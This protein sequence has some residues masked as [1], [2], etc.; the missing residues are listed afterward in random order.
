MKNFL[1]S[2]LILIVGIIVPI[3]LPTLLDFSQDFLANQEIPF[4]SAQIAGIQKYNIPPIS[5]GVVVPEVSA[6]ALL[7]KDL[8][9]DTI[10]LQKNADVPLPIASTTKIMT[11][12]VAEKYFKQNDVL[13]VSKDSLAGGSSAG[14]NLGENLSFR[15]LLYGMLLNSGNDAAY[16][17]A[18]NYP[19]GLPAFMAAMNKEA[20]DLGLKNTHF[21]NPAGFDS[22]NHFSS[23]DDMAIISQ[24]ALKQADLARVFATKETD[25]LSLDKKYDHHLIN[26][27][28]LLSSVSGVLGIKTGTTDL[29]KENLITLVERNNHRVLIILL[30]SSDRFGETTKLINWVYYN[31]T[32]VD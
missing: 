27:N 2:S 14:L 6:K 25:I 5:N 23:A 26:L 19:G 11:A 18:D 9:T 16:T 17:I 21:D 22:P 12:L 1:L 7:I 32:W 28:K 4:N 24:E 31:F 20:E 13:I 15:S 8:T 3:F 30:G 29:A 10:L